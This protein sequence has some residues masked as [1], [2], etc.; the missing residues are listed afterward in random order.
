MKKSQHSPAFARIFRSPEANYYHRDVLDAPKV[1]TDHYFKSLVK[2]NFN[3]IWIAGR[4]RDLVRTKALP[5]LGKNQG[6]HQKALSTIIDRAKTWGVKVYLYLNEPRCLPLND[7][8]FNRHPELRGQKDISVMDESEYGSPEVYAMCASSQGTMDFL[9]EG[10]KNLFEAC[11]G[12]G[13][14]ILITA[15]EHVTTCHSRSGW[16]T[17][18]HSLTCPRCLKTDIPTLGAE[19]INQ[20]GR[21]AWASNRHAEVIAWNWSW[22]SHVEKDPQPKLLAHLD[23][24]VSVMADFERGGTR[25]IGRKNRFIDEY[26]LSYPGPSKR[27]MDFR[28]EALKKNRPLYVK[29]QIGTTHEI[30][31]VEHLPLLQVLWKKCNWMRRN[32]VT[33]TM[34]TWNFGNFFSMNTA[35]FNYFLT[36][37]HTSAEQAVLEFAKSYFRKKIHLRSFQAAIRFFERANSFYPF[38]HSFLYFSPVNYAVAYP[39]DFPDPDKPMAKSWMKEDWG[40]R[41]SDCYGPYQLNEL[42]KLLENLERHWEY[43]VRGLRKSFDLSDERQS[44]VLHNALGIWHSYRSTYHIF[45][46]WKHRNQTKTL[47]SIYRDEAVH[48]HELV[49]YFDKIPHFGFHA[50]CQEQFFTKKDIV[51]KLIALDLNEVCR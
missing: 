7:P 31:T 24:R 2:N 26:S 50:E 5:L 42:V 40:Y 15:S 10:S 51:N 18:N 32:R 20:L 28:K 22:H 14:L 3:G 9:F 38:C 47:A 29:L 35:A 4:L 16:A 1:Y 36:R 12:L 34:A 43:G 33:G 46:A 44:A 39:L 49:R 21:G 25:K 27:F 45:K 48:L 19:I 41:L 11:P 6:L 37:H 17:G 23:P 8:I 13:G 30:A